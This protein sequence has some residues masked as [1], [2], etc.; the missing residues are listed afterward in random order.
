MQLRK[1]ERIEEEY[2]RKVLKTTM[3]CPI[4]QMYLEVGQWPARFEIQKIRLFFLKSILEEDDNSMVSNFFHLQLKQP[5]RGDWATTVQN[6]LKELNILETFDDIKRMS[7][8]KFKNMVKI[9]IKRNAF[10]YL[11]KKRGSKGCQIQY[12][13]LE[14]SEYL[15]PY[16]DKMKIE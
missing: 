13:T 8:T 3:G 7:K 15:L 16:N 5:T 9:R 6:D 2:L 14:M 1:I 4:V 12:S 11:M 10:N